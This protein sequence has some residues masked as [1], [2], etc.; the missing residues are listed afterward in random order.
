M[1]A[2]P[3][4]SSRFPY[5]S[6]CWSV[7]HVERYGARFAAPWTPSSL[8]P[9]T[10]RCSA[11]HC[12]RT[13]PTRR[14]PCSLRKLPYRLISVSCGPR[15]DTPVGPAGTGTTLTLVP[16]FGVSESRDSTVPHRIWAE[17]V[18]AHAELLQ[19]GASPEDR[20]E[21]LN[22]LVAHLG[23]GQVERGQLRTLRQHARELGDEE[24]A[25]LAPCKVD[26]SER[27]PAESPELVPVVA[28]VA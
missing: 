26:V 15:I 25:D 4:S 5:K 22:A 11:P 8:Q 7:A 2:N 9:R 16:A 13:W 27:A 6:K 23:V 24:R 19:N 1:A 17:V 18:A 12:R 28:D 3:A 14:A 10:S 20:H 21:T